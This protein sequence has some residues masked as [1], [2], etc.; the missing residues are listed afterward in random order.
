MTA[1]LNDLAREGIKYTNED[2][3]FLSPLITAHI[4]RFGKY[5]VNLA[6]QPK[7]MDLNALHSGFL[8]HHQPPA[9]DLPN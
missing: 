7:V 8:L 2:L 6:K 5:R 9:E 4:N 3:T 1:I